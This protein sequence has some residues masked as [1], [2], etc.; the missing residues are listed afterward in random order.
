MDQVGRQWADADFEL[1]QQFQKMIFPN[2]V[3]YDAENRR[4]G[5]FAISVLYR[6]ADIKKSPS[7]TLKYLLVAR[8]RLER[9][10]FL[11]R[12]DELIY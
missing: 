8:M 11:V 5:T 1:Q 9:P 4:Y 12:Y 6:L 7:R 2:G 10:L 3:V